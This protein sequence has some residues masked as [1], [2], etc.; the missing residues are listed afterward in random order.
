M[1]DPYQRQVAPGRTTDSLP[2]ANSA[3][4]GGVLGDALINLGGDQAQRNV[5]D[6]K[7][8]TQRDRERQSTQAMVDFAQL[9]EDYASTEIDALL[10]AGPGAAGHSKQMDQVLSEAEKNLLG[11]ISDERVR[12]AYRGRFADWRANQSIKAEAHE[13]GETAKLMRTN[14]ETAINIKANQLSRPTATQDDFVAAITEY[15]AGVGD[16]TGVPADIRMAMEKDGVGVMSVSF[17][18]GRDPTETKALLASGAFDGFLTPAQME[19]ISNGADIDIRRQT[20]EAEARA[21][22]EKADAKEQLDQLLR[23]IGDGV[24]KSDEEL[25]AAAALAGKYGLDKD[26]YDIGKARVE[27][28][29]NREFRDATPAQIDARIKEY[30]TRIARAGDNAKVTDVVARDH[31][32]G[33][34]TTR[35]RDVAKDPLT[36]GAKMGVDVQPID[37]TD[38]NSI[39]ARR[40]AA[41]ASARAL[42][43]PPVYL[44]DEEAT[45]LKAQLDTPAGM[46]AVSAQLRQLGGV[47]SRRAAQQIDPANSWFHASL[48]LNQNA[49][50]MV[51]N[52][53]K[54]LSTKQVS[55]KS[56]DTQP[57]WRE[58]AM[59]AMTLLPTEAKGAVLQ[60]AVRIY[61]HAAVKT[62]KDEFDEDLFD[63]AIN[64]AVGR[65]SR[66]GQMLGGV[67][68]WKGEALIL[69]A[70]MAQSRF[71]AL[72]G[73]VKF[74][75]S[76]NGPEYG[77]GDPI[78][79]D[80]LRKDWTPTLAP[81]GRYRFKNSRGEYAITAK[82]AAYELDFDVLD[83]RLPP[84]LGSSPKRAP[85]QK[86]DFRPAVVPVKKSKNDQYRASG[87]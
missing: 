67:G 64:T 62:D 84:S 31:L 70:G 33:M 25:A 83:R 53:D 52:G 5:E 36:A 72:Y 61:A 68:E 34:L 71:D 77:N 18:K 55:V 3:D 42:G 73:A 1:V 85:A 54:L 69:P 37:W 41:D 12:D 4:Y 57:R 14:A 26:G 17:L 63:S 74:G 23:E 32:A 6:T 78:P 76:K 27:G 20:M 15:R 87:M 66:G 2:F 11:N 56:Q 80:I 45:Q 35:T 38:G 50:Q 21:R 29:L 46:L 30:D 16:L 49:R 59:P 60:M 65:T 43:V 82:G 24:P 13:R 7:L 51:Y 79:A 47:A 22:L 9:Q 19:Q 44:T 48:G 75:K 39:A 58:Y 40:R 86:T 28:Q 81:S 10:N 8:E